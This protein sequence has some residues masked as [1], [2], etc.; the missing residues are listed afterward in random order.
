M[1]N[2]TPT[3]TCI[4]AVNKLL[5]LRDTKLMVPI[6]GPQLCMVQTMKLD[7]KKRGKPV[8]VFASFCPFCG[9]KYVKPEGFMSGGAEVLQ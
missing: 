4:A 2:E 3:C 1:S 9:I 5:A 8:S 7:D 6:Y